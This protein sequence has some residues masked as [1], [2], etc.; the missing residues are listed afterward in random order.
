MHK[1]VTDEAFQISESS[2]IAH[3]LNCDDKVTLKASYSVD[4]IKTYAV[5]WLTVDTGL[6]FL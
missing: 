1:L 3:A 6:I 2:S 5:A 4:A